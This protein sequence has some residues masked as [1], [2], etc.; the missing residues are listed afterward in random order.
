MTARPRKEPDVACAPWPGAAGGRPRSRFPRV[1]FG[2]SPAPEQSG[3]PDEDQV[4]GDDVVQQTRHDEDQDAG[5]QR[6][7]RG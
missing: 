5:D 7:E 4:D 3:R 1:D 6:N 2:A